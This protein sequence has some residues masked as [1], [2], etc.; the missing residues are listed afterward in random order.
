M[1][2]ADVFTFELEL[3]V[4]ERFAE[5]FLQAL[6]FHLEFLDVYRRN[7]ESSLHFLVVHGRDQRTVNFAFADGLDACLVV[8]YRGLEEVKNIFEM[9]V[10][11][12]RDREC[13]EFSGLSVCILAVGNI[14]ENVGLYS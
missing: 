13:A 2:V 9:P 8:R 3:L 14:R 1:I 10:W 6:E 11:K 12:S 5:D 4:L 7:V